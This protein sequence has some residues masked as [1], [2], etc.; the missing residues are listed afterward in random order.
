MKI[1]KQER[2]VIMMETILSLP[3]YIIML[4]GLFWLGELAMTRIALANGENFALWE[5]SNRHTV[6]SI[7]D[8][9]SFLSYDSSSNSQGE[10]VTKADKQ[11]DHFV[12]ASAAYSWGKVTQGFSTV[13]TKQSEWSKGAADSA[14]KIH[15]AQS[16]ISNNDNG[17]RLVYARDVVTNPTKIK[18]FSRVS[19]DNR[20]IYYDDSRDY[21]T[22]H[23]IYSSTWEDNIGPARTYK[24][25]GLDCYTRPYQD[26]LDWSK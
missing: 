1:A 26:Y 3:I 20:N 25:S 9:F 23:D 21:V 11:A 14:Q 18:L 19:S 10:V 8:F 5:E 12:S 24:W 13:S 15:S 22:G 2:G 4:A 6:K 16:G 17:E 7:P